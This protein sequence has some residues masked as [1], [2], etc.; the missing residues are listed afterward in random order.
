MNV[1]LSS[2]EGFTIPLPSPVES[3]LLLYMGAV[4]M[5]SVVPCLMSLDGNTDIG[6]WVETQSIKNSSRSR[7]K[8][9]CSMSL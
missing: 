8:A 9:F 2:P 1:L 4:G 6:V 3:C 5:Y 7:Y